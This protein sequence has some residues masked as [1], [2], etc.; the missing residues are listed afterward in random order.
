MKRDKYTCPV[1]GY[2]VFEN[3]PNSYDICP[4]CYWEDEAMQLRYPNERGAN[5]VTLVE[6]QLNYEEVGYSD[7]ATKNLVREVNEDDEKDYN[8]RKLDLTKDK[9]EEKVVDD[10][11]I[12]IYPTDLTKLYYWED[13]YWL[14]ED[15]KEACKC[16]DE[17]DNCHC[18]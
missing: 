16:D 11:Q 6:A 10:K 7:N 17:C 8:W 4:I 9:I 1:C 14:K 15:N 5:R 12:T 18:H 2:K 13:N 3:E